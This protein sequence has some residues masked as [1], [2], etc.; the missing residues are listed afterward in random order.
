MNN[1]KMLFSHYKK[2]SYNMKIYK[3]LFLKYKLPT[4][5]RYL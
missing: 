5:K 2:I 1:M 3:I 4:I